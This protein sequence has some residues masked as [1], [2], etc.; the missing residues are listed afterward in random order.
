[1]T[2][3]KDDVVRH[4]LVGRIVQAYDAAAVKREAGK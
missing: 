1:V 2:F 4:E 3:T